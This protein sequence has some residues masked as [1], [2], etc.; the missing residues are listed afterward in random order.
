LYCLKLETNESE[1]DLNRILR[2]FLQR[3][4]PLRKT[5]LAEGSRR[6]VR[7]VETIECEQHVYLVGS[8]QTGSQDACP[9]CGKK[10]IPDAGEHA[11]R[12]L[13]E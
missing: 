3:A 12:Q 1:V 2:W 11:P 9:L 13:G 6:T 10:L 4:N 5:S 7:T 8:M